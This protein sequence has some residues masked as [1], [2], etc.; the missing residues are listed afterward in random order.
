MRTDD[1]KLNKLVKEISIVN[2][3][4][5]DEARKEKE[6]FV[7]LTSKKIERY[8]EKLFPSL[9][10]YKLEFDYDGYN[11]WLSV[12]PLQR[13]SDSKLRF[14]IPA[15]SFKFD[16]QEY[17][18]KLLKEAEGYFDERMNSE[19]IFFRQDENED[20]YSMIANFPFGRKNMFFRIG[21]SS[22]FS[23]NAAEKTIKFHF[24]ESD[25]PRKRIAE[26]ILKISNIFSFNSIF[27]FSRGYTVEIDFSGEDGCYYA[28]ACF[29]SGFFMRITSEGLSVEEELEFFSLAGEID[30]VKFSG[31]HFTFDITT[32]AMLLEN[33]VNIF[34]ENFQVFESKIILLENKENIIFKYLKENFS[35]T[36]GWFDDLL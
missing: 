31:K 21:I 32:T 26:T 17:S 20:I 22:K 3:I 6:K 9:D 15:E 19:K 11:V 7:F 34:S 25:V 8:A 13:I 4:S 33:I 18:E 28:Q 5:L 12:S 29:I 14:H 1:R 30:I 27:S 10:S 35:G 36:F 23:Y 2:K 16:S 24:G